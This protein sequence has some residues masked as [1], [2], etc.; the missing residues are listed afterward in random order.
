M[1]FHFTLITKTVQCCDPVDYW[2]HL[3]TFWS[4]DAPFFLFYPSLCTIFSRCVPHRLCLLFAL[5]SCC[6]LSSLGMCPGLINGKWGAHKKFHLFSPDVDLITCIPQNPHSKGFIGRYWLLIWNS[7]R[8]DWKF[9]ILYALSKSWRQLLKYVLF[10]RFIM[11]DT[12]SLFYQL[13]WGY[14]IIW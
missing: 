13:S 12:L 6:L 2:L 5:L 14:D 9:K 11:Q 1:I 4:H 3:A 7:S 8:L 10:N